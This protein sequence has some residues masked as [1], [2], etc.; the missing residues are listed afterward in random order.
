MIKIFFERHSWSL[1]IYPLLFFPAT[2]SQMR[3]L[4]RILRAAGA[5]KSEYQVF[6][7]AITM[8]IDKYPNCLHDSMDKLKRNRKQLQELQEKLYGGV[9]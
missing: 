4:M 2:L 9:K 1:R 7:D 5:T 6:I 3:H 8:M